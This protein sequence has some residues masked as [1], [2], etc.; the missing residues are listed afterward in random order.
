MLL[1]CGLP[2]QAQNDQAKKPKL[3]F[4]PGTWEIDS[5]TTT[6]TG[7]IVSSQ[8]TLCAKEQLDFWKVTQANLACKTP[9][10]HSDSPATLR[11]SVHCEYTGENLHSEILSDAVETF[12][13]HG[14][15]FTL[16]G[17]TTTKTAYQGVHPKQTSIN[18]EATAHR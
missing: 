2:L 10:T 17:T 13:D 4:Q 12:S 18:L 6:P 9:K 8:T 5:V 14:D 11:V 3:H 1:L 15:S 7:R 16:E